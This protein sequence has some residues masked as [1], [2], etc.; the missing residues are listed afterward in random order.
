L[1]DLLGLIFP[2]KGKWLC[3][4]W[5]LLSAVVARVVSTGVVP[6]A[7]FPSEANRA[8]VVAG[9]LDPRSLR[10]MTE[11]SVVERLVAGTLAREELTLDRLLVLAVHARLAALS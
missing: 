2:S 5:Q 9:H 11:A 1:L 7:M 8:R 4:V 10:T 6:R 3:L